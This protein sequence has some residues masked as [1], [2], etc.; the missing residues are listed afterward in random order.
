MKI[1]KKII[2]KIKLN[3]DLNNNIN[4]VIN[5]PSNEDNLGLPIE[6]Q[7]SLDQLLKENKELEIILNKYNIIL[8]EYQKKYGNELF[9]QIDKDLSNIDNQNEDIFFKKKLLE[10]V[11][12]LKE[13]ENKILEID[14]YNKFLLTEN[15]NLESK[16]REIEQQNSNLEMEKEKI[17]KDYEE[18]FNELE[19]RKKLK[20]NKYNK[21]FSNNIINK[22]N[23]NQEKE[24]IGGDDNLN[25]N[26]NMNIGTLF[27][28][29]RENYN[30]LLNKEK[31]DYKE[32]IEYE[33]ILNKLKNEND[34][35]KVQIFGLQNRLKQ[36]IEEITKLE[37]DSNLKQAA[38]DKLEIDNKSLNGQIN[39]YKEAYIS[40][41]NRKNNESE[42]LR[43]ELKDIRI[44]IDNYKN[45][46]KKLE[47]ENANYKSEI[48][49]L[50]QEINGLKFDRDNLSKIIEDSNNLVQE[51]EEKEKNIDNLIKSYKKKA[52]DISLEKEKL[53]KKIEMKE[54]QINK[55]NNDYSNL[56]KEKIKNYE[57]LNNITKNKYEEIIKNKD[58]EIKELKSNIMSY[59]IE[60]DKY[61]SD[62]NL[63]KNEFDKINQIFHIE[64]DGYIKKY[65]EVQNEL[66]NLSNKYI[67]IINEL[68]VKNE[69]LENENRLMKNNISSYN[70]SEKV[71]EQK[72]RYLEKNEDGLKR[73]IIDLKKDNDIYL[74]QKSSHIKEIERLKEQ[75][76]TQI[77]QDKE[78]YD[79]RIIYLENIVEKQ[80]KQL[81]L[82]EGK[83]LDMVKKQQTLTEKYKKELQNTINYYEN[84]I[85]GRITEN[86]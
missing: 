16:C 60:K 65:E 39:D 42:N 2:F 32:K 67:G 38:I 80:N 14:N 19:E 31:T 54:N 56:L 85:N 82:V 10:S 45:N 84:I 3:M 30:N 58:N 25:I 7:I 66:N 15:G 29:M 47:E 21:T 70:K 81:S 9:N 22:E 41:E 62:Y 68:K 71:F 59:K 72:I 6:K 35:L 23:L 64:N 76:K 43:N 79:N 74:K 73:E 12:I 51:A 77:Q 24:M 44:N 27:N 18:I 17:Q 69:N 1:L 26:S 57:I 11:S 63:Y 48:A 83:A 8:N 20:Q 28:T 61:L 50:N 34:N 86:I 5:R 49:K 46:Y 52:D 37:N 55:I 40:L 4:S 75:F 36:E 13:Y 78:V 53:N 33:E